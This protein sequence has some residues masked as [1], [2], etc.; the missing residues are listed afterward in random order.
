MRRHIIRKLESE[1][2]A[3]LNSV[4]PV[5]GQNYNIYFSRKDIGSGVRHVV[6]LTAGKRFVT[7]FYPPY[8]MSF[9]LPNAAWKKLLAITNVDDRVDNDSLVRNIQ[10]RMT[11]Y[12]LHE[13]QYNRANALK[14]CVVLEKRRKG[15]VRAA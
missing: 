1:A 12:D 14:A 5:A 10:T 9:R 6:V 11:Y 8:L 7:I 2:K 4:K 3:L 13:K 15:Y